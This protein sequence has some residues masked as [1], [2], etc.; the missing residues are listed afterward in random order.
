MI[1]FHYPPVGGSSGYL[2]TLKFGKYLPEHGWEADVLTVHERAHPQVDRSTLAEVPVGVQVHRASAWDAKRHLSWKGR[3]PDCLSVPD[4]Y[5]TWLPFGAWAGRKVVRQR[6]IRALYSTSPVPTAHLIGW[7]LH[8][9]TGLPWIADFRDPWI[10]EDPEVPR[11]PVLTRFERWLEKHVVRRATA[12]TATTRRLAAE[13]AARHPN[14]DPGKFHVIMNGFDEEDFGTVGTSAAPKGSRFRLTHAGLLNGTYR[15]PLPLL[16]AAR[17]AIHE[18]GLRAGEMEVCFLGAG[19]YLRSAEFREAV[20]SLGLEDVVQIPGHV[21]YE[22][23]LREMA[24]SDVLL[25]LQGGD[26][27]RNLIPAKLFEYLRI[28]RPVLALTDPESATAEVLGELGGG[29][30]VGIEDTRGIRQALLA[31]MGDGRGEGG[32]PAVDR[33]RLAGYSR[34]RLTGKLAALLDGLVGRSTC[35]QEGPVGG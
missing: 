26:D 11:G 10:E 5:S 20:R 4:N 27:T 21:P 33:E 32:V 17:D 25:L 1:A 9:L 35:F 12:V 6:G 14:L 30:V 8:S 34:R 24:A 16:A 15:N 2:R 3:Y 23:C 28:G 19:D 18:R 29:R 22:Q 7:A 31:R 13:L